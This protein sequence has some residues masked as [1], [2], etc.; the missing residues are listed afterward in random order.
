MVCKLGCLQQLMPGL[1]QITSPQ[2]PVRVG[3]LVKLDQIVELLVYKP[4]D[5]DTSSY[6]G[7]GDQQGQSYAHK[8][9][10]TYAMADPG[11]GHVGL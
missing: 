1:Y 4:L 10:L 6:T 5:R 7:L 2:R 8:I 3:K 9:N 11:G